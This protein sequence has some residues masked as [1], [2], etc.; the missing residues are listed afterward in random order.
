[1][2]FYMDNS[3]LI[4]NNLLLEILRVVSQA[5]NFKIFF[6]NS[7]GAVN[8]NLIIGKFLLFFCYKIPTKF[9]Y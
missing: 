5:P 9:I 2:R 3:N 1:M 8:L 4:S 6:F 7:C